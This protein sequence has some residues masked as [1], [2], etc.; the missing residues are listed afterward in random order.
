M[1]TAGEV[2]KNKRELLEKSLD[3]VSLDT[4]IQKRFLEYIEN[5]QFDYFDSEVFLTGFIK[6][7]AQYLE[8]DTNKI[9]ALYR[10]SN[11]NKTFNRTDNKT[12]KKQKKFFDNLNKKSKLKFLNPKTLLSAFLIVFLVIIIG[13][14]GLQIYKFQSPPSLT[15]T[16]PMNESEFTSEKIT[17]KG[18]SET[19]AT[20]EINGTTVEINE[21]NKFEKEITLKEGS[22][23]IT[24][25]ARKRNTLEKVETLKVTYTKE[26]TQEVEEEKEQEKQIEKTI[27]L[28]VFDSPAWI[29]LD[30][31]NENKLSEVVEPSE[32]EFTIEENLYII[33]GRLSNTRL[34]YNG[35]P[36]DWQ[37]NQSTGV[38]ELTCEVK[39]QTLSC[40]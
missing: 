40:E 33:T 20:V 19:D 22:N 26:T 29:R 1:I 4:K 34:S 39:D 21:D 24:V 14:I 28:E 38:A 3:R 36:L 15:I 6:I 23:I 12:G 5:N 17:V 31:D 27:K 11:P 35:E 2:L 30:V 25:R 18:E 16:Q 32:Y 7:Y 9:L 8:L 10:R 13:Y 37:Q